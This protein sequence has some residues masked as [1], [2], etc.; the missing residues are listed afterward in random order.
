M[1]DRVPKAER[2]TVAEA[3]RR[4]REAITNNEEPN[5]FP[6]LVSVCASTTMR[7]VGIDEEIDWAAE[8]AKAPSKSWI[9]VEEAGKTRA[10]QAIPEDFRDFCAHAN[11]VP[12]SLHSPWSK[13]SYVGGVSSFEDSSYDIAI[14]EYEQWAAPYF[15]P[16]IPRR[17]AAE[18]S[19]NMT[20]AQPVE[21][22]A[23]IDS[24]DI[25][26]PWTQLAVE[27]A[28]I[29]YATA[30]AAGYELN[31]QQIAVKL[32]PILQGMKVRGARGLLTAKN[33]DRMALRGWKP[34]KVLPKA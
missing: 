20:E 31:I 11:V 7:E 26:A 8:A 19:T 5:R 33:I 17:L 21:T 29:V 28:N 13:V 9:N 34:P 24:R 32:V 14:S 3:F 1:S 30:M 22:E 6:D 16:T 15:Q 2:I 4:V 27:Q 18:V 12:R 23:G 25:D 10:I